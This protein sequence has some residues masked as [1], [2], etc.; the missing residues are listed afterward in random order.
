[1]IQIKPSP[2]ADTRTC[3]VTKV[4]KSQLL[5]ASK[6]HIGDV[7]AGLGFFA[8]KL[9]E[10][11]CEF[12][13]RAMIENRKLIYDLKREVRR[14]DSRVWSLEKHTPQESLERLQKRMDDHVKSLKKFERETGENLQPEVE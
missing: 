9:T 2:T 6:Q 5:S 14:L 1:M 12:L 4:K 10:A 3:D 7:G 11:A 13:S 8:A